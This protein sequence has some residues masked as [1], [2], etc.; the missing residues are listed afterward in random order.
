MADNKEIDWA[1][2]EMNLGTN[3]FLFIGFKKINW[4]TKKQVLTS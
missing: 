3:K 4:G 1:E 2:K